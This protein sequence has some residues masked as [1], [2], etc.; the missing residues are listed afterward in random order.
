MV[1]QLYLSGTTQRRLAQHLKTSPSTVAAKFRF[2]AQLAREV[3]NTR[4]KS[5]SF[6]AKQIHFDEMQSFEHTR[7]KPLSIALA[8]SGS[9]NPDGTPGPIVDIQV[10]QL[11][12]RG[13]LANLAQ[14]KY[15]IRAD[16]SGKARKAVL[17]TVREVASREGLKIT[18]DAKAVYR[19]EIR[20]A[21][22][23]KSW[24]FAIAFKHEAVPNRKNQTLHADRPTLKKRKYDPMF[25]LN[26]VAARIRH[27]LSRMQRKVWTTTKHR[28]FLQAHLD[29]FIAFYNR[30]D[31][32]V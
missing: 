30:Y 24:P 16:E 3:H 25:W 27:D 2:L 15:G 10:A 8:V 9:K 29:L 17:E 21:L 22:A 11:S 23:G 31:L 13:K 14:K 18:T 32:G 28:F 12:Y 26:H 4:V 6:S 20:N 19:P 7:L 1:F 5:G